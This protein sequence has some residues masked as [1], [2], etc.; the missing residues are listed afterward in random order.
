MRAAQCRWVDE[1]KWSLYMQLC[2]IIASAAASSSEH[3]HL[4]ASCCVQVKSE[5]SKVSIR[6]HFC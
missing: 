2:R 1:S 4:C 5:H 3:P 6:H